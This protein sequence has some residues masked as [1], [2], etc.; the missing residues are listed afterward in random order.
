MAQ[1]PKWYYPGRVLPTLPA[2]PNGAGPLKFTAVVPARNEAANLVPILHYLKKY[3]DEILLVDGHST[4]GTPELGRALGIEVIRDQGLGKGA[5]LREGIVRARNDYIVCMDADGSHDPG[6]IPSLLRPLVQRDADHV[7]GSRMIGGSEELHATLS[8]SIRLFG[9]QVVTLLINYTQNVRLTDCQNGFRALRRDMA[10]DLRLSENIHTIEQ[11]MIIKSLRCG[12]KV[13][14]VP[15]HEYAR[16]NGD[17]SFRIKD[18]WFRFGI[19]LLYFLFFWKP[20]GRG[21]TT[22]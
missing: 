13:V 11:E 10:M 1:I 3:A 19:T 4:D 12:Y 2:L 21:R 22:G 17:S 20:A 6:D 9:S 7:S 16:A 15:T 8:Q 18:V 5:A 14:E